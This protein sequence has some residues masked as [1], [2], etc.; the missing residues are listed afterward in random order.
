[1]IPTTFVKKIEISFLFYRK[2]AEDSS[3]RAQKN[4]IFA[5]G[6]GR[7]GTAADPRLL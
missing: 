1:M 7:A 5:L 2:K 3:E 4:K 6:P